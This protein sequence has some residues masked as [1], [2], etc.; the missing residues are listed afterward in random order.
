MELNKAK[1]I[2]SFF[3]ILF[4]AGF[5]IFLN[6]YIG[7][8]NFEAITALTLLSASFLGGM[9]GALI[10]LFMI[11]LSDIYFGNTSILLFTWSAFVLIGLF[12]TLIK[13]K[14]KHYLFKMTGAGIISVLFFYLYTNFGWWLL[15]KMYPMTISGLLQCYTAGL[16]FL[17]NQ[18]GSALLF[19][20]A[21]GFL[22]SKA[23]DFK[24]AETTTPVVVE[25]I[26]CSTQPFVKKAGLFRSEKRATTLVVGLY[27]FE[28]HQPVLSIKSFLAKAKRQ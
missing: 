25:A 15:Y 17:K 14:H 3:F 27:F 10:P 19:V 6:E 26:K 16:P 9:Y 21:F 20:P 24:K 11:F 18:L 22:F 12:G 2:F 8:P 23:L 28:K 4:G 5:R 1:L 13:R 7:I